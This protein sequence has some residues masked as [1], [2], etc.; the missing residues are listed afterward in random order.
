MSDSHDI[1]IEEANSQL[2]IR[3]LSVDDYNMTAIYKSTWLKGLNL[4]IRSLNKNFVKLRTFMAGIKCLPDFIAITETWIKPHIS[5]KRFHLPA[6]NFFHIDRTNKIG[7]GVG[8]YIHNCFDFNI[9]NIQQIDGCDLLLG[10]LT[11]KI[12]PNLQI[13]ICVIYRPPKNNLNLFIDKLENILS[14]LP[15][16]LKLSNYNLLLTGDFNVDSLNK[17]NST[18][19][20]LLENLLNV[21]GCFAL[22]RDLPTRV[23]LN[24]SSTLLDNFFINF[25]NTNVTAGTINTILCDHLPTFCFIKMHKDLASPTSNSINNDRLIVDFDLFIT[26]I[27][28]LDLAVLYGLNDVNVAFNFFIEKFK[29]IRTDSLVKKTNKFRYKIGNLPWVGKNILKLIYERDLLFKQLKKN[30]NITLYEN[31][32]EVSK[33]N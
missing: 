14:A 32:S 7:G 15:N 5:V 9:I 27:K 1:Y 28:N 16:I 21:Q 2:S 4:N 33:K 18:K 26:K 24:S 20:Q 23:D 6:Y 17:I 25:Q 22:I 12:T 31:Y 8:L 29:L 11:H 10:Q 19:W 30:N 13:I 3:D